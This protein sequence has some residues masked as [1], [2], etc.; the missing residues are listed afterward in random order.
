MD[1][2][3]KYIVVV[4]D[5]GEAWR[6]VEGI[7]IDHASAW[8]ARVVTPTIGHNGAEELFEKLRPS[9][10]KNSD[11]VIIGFSVYRRET[12]DRVRSVFVP[13]VKEHRPGVPIILIGYERMTYSKYSAEKKG[14]AWA[15]T[16]AECQS[17]VEEMGFVSCYFCDALTME[18]I[19]P[20]VAQGLAARILQQEKLE[21][22]KRCVIL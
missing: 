21:K 19:R 1:K 10:Y 6:V 2:N 5:V 22:K 9:S 13:E 16:K 15:V 17:F 20:A 7:M 3:A 12:F 18:S 8:T 4:G 14:K 11:V